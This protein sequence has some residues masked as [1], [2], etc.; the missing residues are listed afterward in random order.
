MTT[1][2]TYLSILTLKEIVFTGIFAIEAILKIIALDPYYYFK[3]AWNIFD[4]LITVVGIISITVKERLSFF[5]L[6]RIFKLSKFWPTL[7]KLMKIMLKSVGPLGNLTLVLVFTIY[8][9]ALVGMQGFGAYYKSYESVLNLFIALLLS[10]FSSSGLETEASNPSLQLAFAHVRSGLQCVKHWLW[11]PCCSGLT[12]KP[13]IARKQNKNVTISI[14]KAS[15]KKCAT[16][17][18]EMQENCVNNEIFKY[19]DKP[20]TDGKQEDFMPNYNQ[21]I[22]APLAE[23]EFL[24]DEEDCTVTEVD[25]RNQV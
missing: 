18:K 7:N 24:S 5:R 1:L 21:C 25:Y 17:M 15:Q 13:K 12:Q 11:D 19:W 8:I 22:G 20:T 16:E 9:F 2:T 6:L 14:H 3:R 4:F 23:E 10:S